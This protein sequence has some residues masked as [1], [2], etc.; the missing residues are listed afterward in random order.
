M[1]KSR[2]TN[3]NMRGGE[4]GAEVG[5]GQSWRL[6]NELT[7]IDSSGGRI[8]CV[9]TNEKREKKR[10]GRDESTKLEKH[11]LGV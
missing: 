11:R 2:N 5:A 1:T 4:G 8:K 3:E 6:A 10:K 7:E 9:V